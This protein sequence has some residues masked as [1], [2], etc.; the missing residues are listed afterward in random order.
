M[1][2]VAVHTKRSM[3]YENRAAAAFV[4]IGLVMGPHRP[5]VSQHFSHWLLGMSSWACHVVGCPGGV[6]YRGG[7]AS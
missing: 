7:V 2:H 6:Q 5:R 3:I 4:Q 1:G